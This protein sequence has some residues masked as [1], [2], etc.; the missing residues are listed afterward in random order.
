MTWNLKT[1]LWKQGFLVWVYLPYS[2]SYFLMIGFSSQFGVLEDK[3]LE[4]CDVQADDLKW[5]HALGSRL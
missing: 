4:I 1:V 3:M 5:T 2:K